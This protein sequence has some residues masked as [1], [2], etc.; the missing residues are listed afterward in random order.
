MSLPVFA[1]PV[2][3]EVDKHNEAVK[4]W[5]RKTRPHL[6][7]HEITDVPELIRAVTGQEITDSMHDGAWMVKLAL[8]AWI[9]AD[10]GEWVNGDLDSFRFLP[11]TT[12]AL[13]T[14]KVKEVTAEELALGPQ[15]CKCGARWQGE[16]IAHCAVCHLT[17]TTVGNFDYHLY[18]ERCRTE[19]ELRDKGYE[20]NDAGHWRKPIPEDKRPAG[21]S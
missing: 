16:A 21:W 19:A 5:Q 9:D 3:D 18:R 2:G 7:A 17:F 13:K 12:G 1:Q 20:P 10:R 15:R 14:R 11:P 8:W 4:D 6:V